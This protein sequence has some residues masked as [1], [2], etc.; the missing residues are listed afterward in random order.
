MTQNNQALFICPKCNT[1]ELYVL[2][3]GQN[4]FCSVCNSNSVGYYPI[5]YQKA[6]K[7]LEILIS[8][9]DDYLRDRIQQ[10]YDRPLL[11]VGLIQNISKLLN[12]P[13][14]SLE[15]WFSSI[16]LIKKILAMEPWCPSS[17]Q[18]TKIVNIGYPVEN[19]DELLNYNTKILRFEEWLLYIS[20]NE[21][22]GTLFSQDLVFDNNGIL[23]LDSKTERKKI[24]KKLL[25][26]K[27]IWL[28][29]KA[30][31]Q[32]I[33]PSLREKGLYPS[34]EAKHKYTKMKDQYEKDVKEAM[35]T[36]PPQTIPEFL[37]ENLDT[38]QEFRSIFA[39]HEQWF[40][41]LNTDLPIENLDLSPLLSLF[42]S[43]TIPNICKIE[44]F[45]S[46]MKELGF[47]LK[48]LNKIMIS[49]ESLDNLPFIIQIDD[50][51]II[52]SKRNIY[53]L[54]LY[55]GAH[56][57][58]GKVE[59]EK[60]FQ[61][62]GDDFE[63]LIV[64]N[65]F[66]Q[67]NLSPFHHKTKSLEID[68]IVPLKTHILI[69]EVKRW[70]FKPFFSHRKMINY[71]VR[72]LR[73]VVD[74]IKYTTKDGVLTEQKR[75]PIE[76]KVRYVYDNRKSLSLPLVTVSGLV[77]TRFHPPIEEYKACHFISYE[78]IGEFVQNYLHNYT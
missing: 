15:K 53:F 61:K 50:E 10:K 14:M 75:V 68:L 59:L 11:L 28:E 26:Y 46:K 44:E 64:P 57:K 66:K 20:P 77:I 8:S 48:I 45:H 43:T 24:Q 37:E 76:E 69:V 16:Q 17:N 32:S 39:K 31:C 21:A 42:N 49:Q 56:S 33:V 23:D 4:D 13:V 29:K 78:K 52:F 41:I 54:L 34:D 65:I 36:P 3:E 74:G 1:H 9:I 40:K 25:N 27:L 51:R 71:I 38:I 73:G 18:L 72:D 5:S 2:K 63:K 67:L 62:D 7:I 47:D 58:H 12:S 35:K 22:W 60:Y 6:K 55:Y 19:I 30:R 70:D